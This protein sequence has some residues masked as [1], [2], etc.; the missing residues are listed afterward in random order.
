MRNSIRPEFILS[1][2]ALRAKATAEKVNDYLHLPPACLSF[3]EEF[4]EAFLN[5]WIDGIKHL[6]KEINNVLCVGHNPVIS[7]LASE[8]SKQPIDLPPSG[9]ALFESD[10]V[11]WPEFDNHLRQINLALNAS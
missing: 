8:F 2:S 4:Y 9:F 6:P 3:R 11:S 10:S 1:S 7:G 5:T